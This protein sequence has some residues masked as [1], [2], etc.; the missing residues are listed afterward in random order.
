MNVQG[1]LGEQGAVG[2]RQVRAKLW[3]ER[4]VTVGDPHGMGPWAEVRVSLGAV[5]LSVPRP[6]QPSSLLSPVTPKQP[7]PLGWLF[8]PSSP[9]EGDGKGL[10]FVQGPLRG[11]LT[12][13]GCSLPNK[14]LWRS[15]LGKALW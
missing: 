2:K 8:W 14:W 13:R 7:V 15:S 4:E 12:F 10:G 5:V 6:P 9:L 11:L 1:V 3:I